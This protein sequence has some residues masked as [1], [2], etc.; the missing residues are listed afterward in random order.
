MYHLPYGRVKA[1]SRSNGMVFLSHRISEQFAAGLHPLVSC[2]P[3]SQLAFDT[4]EYKLKTKNALVKSSGSKA[5]SSSKR[6]TK[7]TSVQGV[8]N[9]TIHLMASGDYD[10]A[11]LLCASCVD[12]SKARKADTYAWMVNGIAHVMRA[13][14][15]GDHPSCPHTMK[16]AAT[17]LNLAKTRANGGGQWLSVIHTFLAVAYAFLSSVAQS[18]KVLHFIATAHC[19]LARRGHFRGVLQYGAHSEIFAER[20]AKSFFPP[21]TDNVHVD[22]QFHTLPPPPPRA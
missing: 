14:P 11:L 6:P 20:D 15:S 21:E 18:C 3:P 13:L 5:T 7:T 4:Q 16:K 10:G 19:F 9:D 1:L 8:P 17:M 2:A 22:P 12:G